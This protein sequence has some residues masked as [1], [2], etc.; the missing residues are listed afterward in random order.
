MEVSYEKVCQWC[1]RLIQG[2]RAKYKST[3]YHI[4]CAYK[5][6]LKQNAESD[7]RTYQTRREWWIQYRARRR[8]RA[9]ISQASE[10]SEVGGSAD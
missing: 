9:G 4:L 1:C 10:T 5:A 7:K 8:N 6:K 3:K 2:R